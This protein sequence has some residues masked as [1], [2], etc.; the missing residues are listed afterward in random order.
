MIF[1]R[2][3]ENELFI[4]YIPIFYDFSLTLGEKG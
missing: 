2:D 3:I 1:N 4:F